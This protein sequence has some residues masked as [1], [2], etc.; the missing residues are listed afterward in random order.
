MNFLAHIYLSGNNEEVKIGNFIGDY[1]KGSAFHIYPEKIK[2]GILL[3]RSI[4]TFTDKNTHTLD[5]KLLF[6][7]KYRK[8]AGVVIDIIYDHFLASSWS[9]YSFVSLKEYI[10]DFHELLIKHN[11]MLPTEVQN[12]VPKLIYNNRLYS[13]KNIEGIRLVLSTMSNYTSL[14]D[15]SNFA[16]DVLKN[17]YEFL[18]QKFF[19]FF[20]DII[21]YIKTVHDIDIKGI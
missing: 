6:A 11:D 15:H 5:A 17:N 13:Y 16:I 2:K 4:D 7:P 3:H 8:Y 20:S 12:F 21:Y 19:L 18:K 1:V 10:D 9:K 14:P